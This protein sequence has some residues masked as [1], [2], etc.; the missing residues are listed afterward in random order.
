MTGCTR[1]APRSELRRTWS[2][3]LLAL[4]P[5]CHRYYSVPRDYPAD[6]LAIV[7]GAIWTI[8]GEGGQLVATETGRWILPPTPVTCGDHWFTVITQVGRVNVQVRLTA[9]HTYRFWHDPD[10][11]DVRFF[12]T[13]VTLGREI[14][15]HPIT[16]DYYGYDKVKG[17]KPPGPIHP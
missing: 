2:I 16:L 9:G 10:S 15:L 1:T 3:A 12:I 17:P 14:A 8:D 5:A 4:L 11:E 6:Q 7:T 13:N